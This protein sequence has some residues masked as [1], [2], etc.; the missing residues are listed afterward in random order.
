MQNMIWNYK[1]TGKQLA[2]ILII[3]SV[4]NL[5]VGGTNILNKFRSSSTLL[6]GF[7]Q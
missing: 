7:V 2:R 3:L 1:N 5:E 4:C 6:A